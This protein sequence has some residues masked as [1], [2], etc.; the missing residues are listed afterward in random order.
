MGYTHYWHQLRD[1]TTSEWK[2]IRAETEKIITLAKEKH[3]ELAGW[4]GTGRPEV[5]NSQIRLNGQQ[6]NDYEDIC[7]PRKLIIPSWDK[8]RG[9]SSSF[10]KTEH[11]PYD[12][13]VVSILTILM[14]VAP[15]AV[16]TSSDG[17]ENAIRYMF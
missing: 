11:R 7:I 10:C 17:G 6:P 13:V 12:A 3:I 8:R 1:F 14:R 4:D 9:Y 15:N 16:R 2:T 5:N